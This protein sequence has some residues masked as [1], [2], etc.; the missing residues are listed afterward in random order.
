MALR[1]L[2]SFDFTGDSL[3]G[4]SLSTELNKKWTA[5]SIPTAG[6]LVTGWGGIGKALNLTNDYNA[7]IEK[8]LDNQ[9]EWYVGFAVSTSDLAID[10]Y[11]GRLLT[12]YDTTNPQVTIRLKT[13]T[14]R[15]SRLL[16]CRSNLDILASSA[17][18]P[19]NFTSPWTYIEVYAKIDNT[20]GAV[21]VKVNG[22][23]LLSVTSVDTQATT[24]A[25]ANKIRFSNP[26]AASIGGATF[27]LDDIYILD[28]T[29]GKNTYLGPG[30]IEELHPTSDATPN[31]WTA[32]GG[33]SHYADVDEKPGDNGTT[34]IHETVSGDE[35]QFGFSDLP[36][37]TTNI[38]GI[39][40]CTG[41]AVNEAGSYTL[42]D[43][44]DDGP[45]QSTSNH[46]VNSTTYFVKTSIR[47]NDPSGSAWTASNLNAS[48]FGVKVG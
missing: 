16:I 13:D 20:T 28:S 24:N 8:T 40:I 46:T 25:Y 39:Q 42:Q 30:K 11:Q 23:N 17:I 38:Q 5:S 44:C 1:F 41:A 47:E 35:E 36:N 26:G 18:P 10:V 6:S 33:G 9:A 2:E 45:N 34:Y 31:Q 32:S 4:S 19:F 15:G 3:T 37:I 22:Q 29:S 12:F 48:T 7:Y 43:L 14:E 27:Y 21:T